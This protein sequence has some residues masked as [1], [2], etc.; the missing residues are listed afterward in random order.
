[1]KIIKES[2]QEH[3]N[4]KELIW[5]LAKTDFKLRYQGSVLGYVWAVLQPLLLFLVLAAV[6]SGVFGTGARGGGI[7]NYSLQL[8]VALM[9]FTFFSEGT[10]A[11]MNALKSKAQLVTKIYVPRWSIILASTINTGMVFLMNIIVII[12]FFIGF[13]F[14]PSIA[15]IILSITFAVALYILI[16]SFSL[17]T[18]PLLLYL[19][20]VAMIW[21]VALRVMFYI[22][23]ILYP[24][25]MLPVWTHKFIL[26]NPVAF[27]IHFTKESMF[28]NHYPDL[29]QIAMFI[30][31]IIAFF[32]FSIW[33]YRKLITNVAEK[34]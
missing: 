14:M 10:N 27:I 12:A 13:Q 8:L 33:A 22:L 20:D 31:V 17:I 6:F 21:Q 28:N 9:L 11:G 5:M 25:T 4:Y 15:S 29:S 7:E 1:M 34:I 19:R 16:L 24:L 2:L 3:E 32:I 26:L 23:P 30:S 18:A